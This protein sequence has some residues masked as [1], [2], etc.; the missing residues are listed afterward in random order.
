[1]EKYT[2]EVEGIKDYG[3]GFYLYTTAASRMSDIGSKMAPMLGKVNAFMK[4]NNITKGGMPFTIFNERDEENSTVIFSA[5]IPIAERILITEGDVLCGY[6]EPMA[7]V[8]TVLSGNYTNLSEAYDKGKAYV[9]ENN[10][11]IDPAK[12]MFEV[13]ANDPEDLPNPAEW[14]TEIYIPVFKDLRSNHPIINNNQ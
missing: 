3:G 9:A 1:M 4:Q 14:R 12:K 7:A 2:I 10:L 13:Y 6:M 11:I 5:A 8:K